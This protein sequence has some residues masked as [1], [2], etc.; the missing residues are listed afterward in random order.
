MYKQSF[1]V[2][3]LASWILDYKYKM[4]LP[5]QEHPRRQESKQVTQPNLSTKKENQF[6]II[7]SMHQYV[8]D[9]RKNYANYA[10]HCHELELEEDRVALTQMLVE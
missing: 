5:I 10:S 6:D 2:H 9:L 7:N 8:W 4:G 3:S 1:S